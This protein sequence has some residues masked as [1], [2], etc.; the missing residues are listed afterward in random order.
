MCRA[1]L[2]DRCHIAMGMT[3][4]LANLYCVI[5]DRLGHHAGFGSLQAG[6]STAPFKMPLTAGSFSH[7]T[8][9]SCDEMASE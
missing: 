7:C 9:F 1:N 3:A 2:D 4:T 5:I 8:P 6:F